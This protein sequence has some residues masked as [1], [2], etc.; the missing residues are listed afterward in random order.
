MNLS[1]TDPIVRA[2]KTVNA[3]LQ[4]LSGTPAATVA[5]AMGVSEP[6]ISR[7]KNEHLPQFATMLAHLG[8]KIVPSEM[9]CYD[10]EYVQAILKLAKAQLLTES[11]PP[12]LEWE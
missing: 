2:R 8:L 3:V 4:A 12:Q 9:K 1:S 7:L 11:D 5:V 10:P 6:T